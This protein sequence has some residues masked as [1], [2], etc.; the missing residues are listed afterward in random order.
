MKKSAKEYEKNLKP[1]SLCGGEGDCDWDGCYAAEYYWVVCWDCLGS[2]KNFGNII[3]A[4]EAWDR[5]EL[6]KQGKLDDALNKVKEENN[7]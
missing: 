6:V 4:C 1:C 7:G 5:G 3:E 2:T